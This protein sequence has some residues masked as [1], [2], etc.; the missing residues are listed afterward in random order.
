MAAGDIEEVAMFVLAQLIIRRKDYYGGGHRCDPAK[1]LETTVEVMGPMGKMEINL[2]PE[3]S[4]K[5]V[6]LIADEVATAARGV[7]NAMTASFI[8]GGSSEVVAKLASK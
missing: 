8:E 7:A 2:P 3:V 6:A 5:V 1:P 4:A